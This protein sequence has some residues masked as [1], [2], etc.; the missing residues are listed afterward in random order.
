MPAPGPPDLPP[1]LGRHPA[2]RTAAR[3]SRCTPVMPDGVELCLFEPGDSAGDS[4][5]RVELTGRAHGTCFA[6]V[7]DLR[8]GQRYGLRVHGPWEPERGHRHNPAKLLLDPYARGGRGR[9]HL[10]AR[11]LRAHRRGRPARRHGVPATTA[12][13][14]RTCRAAWCWTTASTG[15]TTGARR[16][17]GPTPSSTRRTSRASPRAT[18]RCPEELRGTYAGLADPHV[19]EHL[20]GLGVTTVE[21]LPVHTF[22]SEPALAQRGAPQLLGLQHP[23]LPGS[24]RRVRRGAATRSRR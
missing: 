10:G 20:V 8:A 15:A 18:R 13:P 21:L 6:R 2:R 17:R 9:R 24:A 12:T 14:R 3:T 22:V 7:P 19:I 4:E 23:Q 5:R 11:G 1:P 16:C